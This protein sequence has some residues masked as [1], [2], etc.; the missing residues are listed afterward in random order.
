MQAEEAK[1]RILEGERSQAVRRKLIERTRKSAAVKSRG[2]ETLSQEVVETVSLPHP[3]YIDSADGG[4]MTDVDGNTY[5]D[6][7]MGFGPCVLGHRPPAVTAAL[8]AQL[9]NGWHFGI[10]NAQQ[11]ELAELVEEAS[12]CADKVVF[13]NT[14]TEATMYAMRAARAFTGKPKI[15]SFAG[16][17]HGA[18]DYALIHAN[19]N[20]PRSK[21]I[22]MSVGNG[23]P[24]AIREETMLVLPYRND[25]AFELIREHRDELAAVIVE[26][27]QNSNPRLDSGA[28]L[29]GLQ[30]ACRENDVLLCFDEVVTGFRIAYGGCQEYYGITPDLATYGKAI[31]AGLPIGAVAGRQ[32]VMNCFSGKNGAPRVFSGGTFGGNPLSMTAGVAA[33]REMRDTKDT[34]YPYLMEQGNRLASE[35]NRVLRRTQLRHPVHER[36]FDGV[37]ALP[38]DADQRFVRLHRG[39][40]VG[41]TG[42][43]PASARLRRHHPGRAPGLPLRCAQ[44]RRRRPHHRRLQTVVRGP[45]RRRS[46]LT[47]SRR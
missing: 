45:A 25:A 2:A 27:S 11:V 4:T 39:R 18:H 9:E 19:P 35:V 5:I 36:R 17:Y 33:M 1:Q 13:C 32:E 14:G 3:I 10:P 6:M 26:P 47:V 20:S 43:L 21:P 15:A 24:D 29:E 41:G 37:S 30:T 8:A 44:P 34:L 23:I 31:A 46:L 38:G 42:V 28:F 12:P 16:S 7:T 22:G 40:Q